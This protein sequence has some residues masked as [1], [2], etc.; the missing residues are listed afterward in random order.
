MF[1][2]WLFPVIVATIFVLQIIIVTFGGLAFNVYMYYGLDI[3]Q[4]LLSVGFGALGL[5]VGLL[6]KMPCCR[7]KKIHH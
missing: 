6:S 7:P 4:W 2:S 5:L 3:Y 1:N